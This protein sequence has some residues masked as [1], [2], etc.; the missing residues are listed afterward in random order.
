MVRFNN[1]IIVFLGVKYVKDDDV[2]ILWVYV[3]LIRIF[4][5]IDILSFKFYV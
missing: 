2:V 4:L 5:C 3:Y 1:I